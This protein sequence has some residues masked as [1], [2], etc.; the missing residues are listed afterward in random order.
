MSKSRKHRKATAAQD[1]RYQLDSADRVFIDAMVLLCNKLRQ[2][3][4]RTDLDH[5]LL[6]AAQTAFQRMPHFCIPILGHDLNILAI[7]SA[8]N[9]ASDATYRGTLITFSEDGIALLYGVPSEDFWQLR[10]ILDWRAMR[11][12]ISERKDATLALSGRERIEPFHESLRR[13]KVNDIRYFAV[14]RFKLQRG[15]GLFSRQR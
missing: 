3:P 11:G 7:W 10:S 4:D 2:L 5:W 6:Q 1:S 9:D 12:S 13:L 15:R 8:R 14:T